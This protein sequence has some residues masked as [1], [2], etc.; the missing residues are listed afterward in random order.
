M[1]TTPASQ[2]QHTKTKTTT[3]A[4]HGLQTGCGGTVGAAQGGFC[5]RARFSLISDQAKTTRPS[6]RG[7]GP[8]CAE[9]A[10]AVPLHQRPLRAHL[11]PARRVLPGPR[12]SMEHCI[13][14][15][16][17]RLA[18]LGTPL[19]SHPHVVCE[20]ADTLRQPRNGNTSCGRRSIQPSL[21]WPTRL[22]MEPWPSCTC[23]RHSGLLC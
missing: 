14:G 11:L 13:R 22:S 10:S 2:Q 7:A 5:R 23:S 16:Q 21:V 20:V 4:G 6:G 15:R 8:R 12:A 9:S 1:G 18:D 3:I 17:R 19:N